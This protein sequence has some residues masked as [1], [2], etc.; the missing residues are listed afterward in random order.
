[1]KLLKSQV[2]QWDVVSGMDVKEVIRFGGI[3]CG[4]VPEREYVETEKRM[5]LLESSSHYSD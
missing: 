5:Y 1:L 3:W 2:L 4:D